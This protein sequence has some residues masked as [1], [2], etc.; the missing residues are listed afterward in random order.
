VLYR[1]DGGVVCNSLIDFVVSEPNLFVLTDLGATPY[2]LPKRPKEV[3][4]EKASITVLLTLCITVTFHKIH[5]VK[6]Q[7]FPYANTCYYVCNIIQPLR[8]VNNSLWCGAMFHVMHVLLIRLVE[9]V[10]IVF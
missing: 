5:K 9:P 2:Y 7:K 10:M 6:L 3:L 1:F 4:V 8:L